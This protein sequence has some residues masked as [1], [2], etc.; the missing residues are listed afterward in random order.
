MNAREGMRRLGIVL[1]VVGGV[2][3][4]FFGY[5]DAQNLWNTRTA[6]RKF[7]SLMA[8]PAVQEATRFTT[9]DISALQEELLKLEQAG[10]PRAA[11]VMAAQKALIAELYRRRSQL[12]REKAAIVEELA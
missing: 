1:G 10:D 12:P 8:L 3:G 5:S 6:H 11:K 4:G 2:I 7:E 9:E